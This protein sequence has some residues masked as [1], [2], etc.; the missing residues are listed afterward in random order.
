MGAG[1]R[2]GLDISAGNI[3]YPGFAQTDWTVI[4]ADLRAAA[5]SS[6][7]LVQPGTYS[8]SNVTPLRVPQNANRVL[9]RVRYA[10]AISAAATSPSCIVY[11]AY[12]D[13]SAFNESTGVFN[14]TGSIRWVRLDSS[15][16]GGTSGT[17]FTMTPGANDDIRDSVYK[18]GVI[19]GE[20]SGTVL[21]VGCGFD[22][23]G[24]KWVMALTSTSASVTGAGVIQLEAAFLSYVP[25]GFS[26]P[27]V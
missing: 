16:S 8:D 20:Q 14:N 4:H 7:V 12:G 6:T 9:L 27:V 2:I 26:S 3:V 21:G 13:D 19:A 23:R 1:K 17:Q 11:G 5:P 25:M 10:T 24:C 15:A 22:L 18:Y